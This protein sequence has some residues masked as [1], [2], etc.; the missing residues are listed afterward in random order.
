MSVIAGRSSEVLFEG[1]VFQLLGHPALDVLVKF[2]AVDA[3]L[4]ALSLSNNFPCGLKGIGTKA[5]SV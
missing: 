2:T 5:T 4:L 3:T 1:T